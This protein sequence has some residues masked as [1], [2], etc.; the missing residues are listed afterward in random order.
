MR[1]Q[2]QILNQLQTNLVDELES[3]GVFKDPEAIEIVEK[4]KKDAKK[5]E[6]NLRKQK[7]KQEEVCLHGACSY[8]STIMQREH[9]GHAGPVL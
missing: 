6:D 8:C 5:V 9:A 1:A 2:Q 4:Y 7:I 3:T